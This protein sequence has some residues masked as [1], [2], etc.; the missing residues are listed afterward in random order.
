MSATN[1]LKDNKS[2]ST[3]QKKNSDSTPSDNSLM[4]FLMLISAFI[5]GGSFLLNY[6]SKGKLFKD[7]KKSNLPK[8]NLS[9]SDDGIETPEGSADNPEEI[10][11]E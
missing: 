3:N 5:I 6:L 10:K 7:I 1:N 2:K 4:I 8:L 11:T 9:D